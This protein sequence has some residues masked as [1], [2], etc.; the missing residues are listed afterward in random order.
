MNN[1]KT[2]ELH[3]KY[4]QFPKTEFT[5]EQHRLFSNQ[6]YM[7]RRKK[8]SSNLIINTVLRPVTFIISIFVFYIIWTGHNVPGGGFVAGLTTAAGVVLVYVNYGSGLIN[9]KLT[10]DFKYLIAIGLS[11]SMLCGL[12]SVVF[13]Y[14]FLTQA[15]GR[16]NF[17]VLGVV[18]YATALIFDIGVYL[19]VTGGC[20]TIITSIGQSG[21]GVYQIVDDGVIIILD[22][23]GKK[24]QY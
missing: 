16:V 21:D 7:S 11:S 9:K 2:P 4:N 20:L 5:E 18:Q 14:P 13:G 6:E 10:F 23:I 1:N 19:T 24:E 8:L 12:A 22:S 15:F 17:P 3:R